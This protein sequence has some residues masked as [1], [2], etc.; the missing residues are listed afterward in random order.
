MRSKIPKYLWFAF[1]ISFFSLIVNGFQLVR[2]SSAS[3]ASSISEND[4]LLVCKIGWWFRTPQH[5]GVGMRGQIV[6]FESPDQRALMVKRILGIGGDRVRMLQGKLIVNG[7][8]VREPYARH[9]AYKSNQSWPVDEHNAGIRDILVPSG[10]YF[11][12]GDNRD[13]S[14]DSRIFGTIPEANVIGTVVCIFP[15]LALKV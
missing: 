11:V 10:Q 5:A 13:V 6:V 3:M 9:D 7:T 14:V 12:L 2:V 4:W 15:R 1:L 8:E